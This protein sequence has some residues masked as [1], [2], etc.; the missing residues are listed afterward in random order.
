MNR[1]SVLALN[2]RPPGTE[3]SGDKM[4]HWCLAL[5]IKGNLAE[6]NSTV[7]LSHVICDVGLK[8]V[9]VDLRSFGAFQFQSHSTL[10]L[11][12]VFGDTMVNEMCPCP[13]AA[14]RSV[15]MGG[16]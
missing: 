14:G 1:D 2:P 4:H 10:G 5:K 12:Q 9:N 15:G 11:F 7:I 8:R 3:S 6:E 13:K 16:Q